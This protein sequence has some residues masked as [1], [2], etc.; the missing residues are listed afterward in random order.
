MAE[1]PA[2]LDSALEATTAADARVPSAAADTEI[3]DVGI[4]SST[5]GGVVSSGGAFG[6]SL[7][8]VAK[9]TPVGNCIPSA[10]PYSLSP[11]P[12]QGFQVSL[13]PQPTPLGEPLG[14]SDQRVSELILTVPSVVHYEMCKI[15]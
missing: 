11:S 2:A 3:I 13:S 12:S 15:F 10:T 8:P 6:Q 4:A 9:Q 1:T 5:E 7:S 14:R